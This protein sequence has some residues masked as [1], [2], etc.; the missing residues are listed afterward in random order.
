MEENNIA[1]GGGKCPSSPTAVLD[2]HRGNILCVHCT[3]YLLTIWFGV[4]VCHLS[5]HKRIKTGE[6]IEFSKK[7]KVPLFQC[8]NDHRNAVTRLQMQEIEFTVFY[9]ME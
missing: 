4:V 1:S 3:L 8:K 7:K 9:F 6:F 5:G 2:A